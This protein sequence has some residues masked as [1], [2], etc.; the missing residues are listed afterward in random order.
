MLQEPGSV[1]DPLQRVACFLLLVV[2]SDKKISLQKLI[3]SEGL[4]FSNLYHVKR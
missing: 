3:I 1:V 2:V 4:V